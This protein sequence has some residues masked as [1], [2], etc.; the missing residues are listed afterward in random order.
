MKRAIFAGL[1]ALTV[2]LSSAVADEKISLNIGTL[3]ATVEVPK[4]WG[5]PQLFSQENAD[6]LEFQLPFF[7]GVP[8]KGAAWG[9]V[10]PKD[11]TTEIQ[12]YV[13]V[14]VLD[15]SGGLKDDPDM[16]LPEEERPPGAMSAKAKEATIAPLAAIYKASAVDAPKFEAPEMEPVPDL[17]GG[18]WGG[19]IG[20]LDILEI[21]YIENADKSLRGVSF[22]YTEGGDINFSVSSRVV[23]YS[24]ELKTVAVFDLPLYSYP[25]IQ[26]LSEA[27]GAAGE[28][29]GILEQYRK[30]L[31]YVRNKKVWDATAMGKLAAQL[32]AAAKSTVV[33]RK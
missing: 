32:D 26:K 23:L 20:V 5:A 12:S 7:D 10:V 29:P 11:S 27:V 9:S 21:H 3:S 25:E 30:G 4:E 31:A 13:T 2:S 33:S 14:T 22:L 15:L 17:E 28:G 18:W 1:V 8:F 6:T 16:K 19:L 24:P